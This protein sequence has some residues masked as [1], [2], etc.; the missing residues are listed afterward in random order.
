M[1]GDRQAEGERETD[2]QRKRDRGREREER[3]T[4]E[5][6]GE[7]EGEGERGGRYRERG[8]KERE[9]EREKEREGGGEKGH[10]GGG[11]EMEIERVEAT[12]GKTLSKQF[13]LVAKIPQS[14]GVSRVTAFVRKRKRGLIFHGETSQTGSEPDSTMLSLI[15]PSIFKNCT[16]NTAVCKHVFL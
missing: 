9:R 6:K 5:R 7:R 8:E 15:H 10:G 4:G 12:T 11:R 3:G 1:R 16:E 13:C 14:V 2:R